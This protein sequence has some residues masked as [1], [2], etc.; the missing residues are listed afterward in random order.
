[1]NKSLHNVEKDCN[2]SKRNAFRQNLDNGNI[3]T[4]SI[5]GDIKT[6][7]QVS[8]S[9]KI[10][11]EGPCSGSDRVNL[12]AN[13]AHYVCSVG[14]PL[15]FV[16]Y[17]SSEGRAEYELKPA[18]HKNNEIVIEAGFVHAEPKQKGL[19]TKLLKRLSEL[20]CELAR[21]TGKKIAHEPLVLNT[22]IGSQKMFSKLG[23][24]ANRPGKKNNT[25]I[26]R[27]EF[28]PLQ[29]KLTNTTRSEKKIIDWFTKSLVFVSEEQQPSKSGAAVAEEEYPIGI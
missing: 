12:K 18:I 7:I 22:N 29:T 20:F 27:K 25:V 2:N 11:A 28:C 3:T 17:K 10:L 13:I 15:I 23:Y 16:E 26:F 5:Q 4:T 14:G 9:K 8:S 19:G 24:N 21:I 6:A 1:M